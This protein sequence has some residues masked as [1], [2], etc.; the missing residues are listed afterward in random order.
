MVYN[1][2]RGRIV[3]KY[4][5]QAAFA[6]TLGLSY[7]AVSNKMTGKASF[8]RQD[9]VTWCELLDISRDLIGEYFYPEIPRNL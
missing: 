5:S 6:R 1:K 3:E 9:I 4:E 8:S 7:N 2:L